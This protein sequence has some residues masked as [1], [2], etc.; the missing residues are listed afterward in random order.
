MAFSRGPAAAGSEPAKDRSTCDGE[1][2]Q[3]NLVA[4]HRLDQGGQRHRAMIVV[5][6]FLAISRVD[7]EDD[8]TVDAERPRA[9]RA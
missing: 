2:I 9:K 4:L 6:G 5:V 1:E 3:A 8:T 7:V